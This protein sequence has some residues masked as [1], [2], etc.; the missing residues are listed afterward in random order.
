LSTK[1]PYR[2]EEKPKQLHG[3]GCCCYCHR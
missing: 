1:G 2:I 3:P